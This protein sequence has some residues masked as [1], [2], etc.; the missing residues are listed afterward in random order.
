MTERTSTPLQDLSAALA[1]AVAGVAPALVSVRSGR[2]GS[3]GFVWRAG[4]I[5][6]ADEA[7][8]EEGEIAV[9]LPG[10]EAV[11][12]R[13]AGR[14]PTTDMALLRVDR[15]DLTPVT[16]ATS[17]VEVGELAMVVAAQ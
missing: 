14:D 1:R 15:P 4:L 7:L 5:V 16:L 10:G 13:L 11:A 12:A 6:T 9:T 3:T 2:S 8:A 17:P